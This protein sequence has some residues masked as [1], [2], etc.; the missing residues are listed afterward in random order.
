MILNSKG[1]LF[2]SIENWDFELHFNN[3]FVDIICLW[4]KTIKFRI[5]KM[6]HRRTQLKISKPTFDLLGIIVEILVLEKFAF[7]PI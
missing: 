4:G 6:M 5:L 2:I 1:I 3:Y 7:Q